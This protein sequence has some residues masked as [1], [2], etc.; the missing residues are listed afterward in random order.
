[1]NNQGVTYTFWDRSGNKYTIFQRLLEWCDN[2]ELGVMGDIVASTSFGTNSSLLVVQ[3][4]TME[5]KPKSHC[6]SRK[7]SK[8]SK[9]E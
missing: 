3:Q 9:T 4:Y 7:Y 5:R 8:Y 6:R 2:P 1:M